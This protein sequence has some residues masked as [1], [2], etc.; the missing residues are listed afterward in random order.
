MEKKIALI[1][2]LSLILT[3]GFSQEKSKKELKEEQTRAK[4]LQIETLVNSKDFIFV[5]RFA[6]PMGGKQIN[7]TSNPNY[8]KFHP[9]LLEGY[10]PFFGKAYSGIGYG[11]DATIKFNAKPEIYNFEKKKKNFQINAT[12][13]GDNDVY[14]L[15][16]TVSFEG[17]ATLSVISNNRA[18]IS[19]QGEIS[20]PGTTEK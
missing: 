20:A 14:K 6:M 2:L 16:L 9:D 18:S 17:S 12:V 10:M 15:S 1:L 5:A 11:G 13:K 7:L 8:V 3:S 4:Q 19:Y